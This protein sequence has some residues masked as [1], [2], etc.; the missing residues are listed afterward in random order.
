MKFAAAPTM[1]GRANIV[2]NGTDPSAKS[3]Q[4]GALFGSPH[5]RACA[6]PG[7][8]ANSAIE[9]RTTPTHR[10]TNSMLERAA[11]KPPPAQ[12]SA[13]QATPR[14]L[15]IRANQEATK[16]LFDQDAAEP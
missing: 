14:R 13:S 3:T 5:S 7:W 8:A 9:P 10:F 1:P 16:S 2:Q 12:P 11:A 4:T 15:A 6:W